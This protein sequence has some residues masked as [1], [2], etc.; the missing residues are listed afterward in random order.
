MITR[1]QS[2]PL[3]PA[4][5]LEYPQAGIPEARHE[6]PVVIV[7]GTLVDKQSIEAYRDY[8]IQKGHPVD[9]QNY[10]GIT[11]GALLQES[12]RQVSQNINQ[13]R[14]ELARTHLAELQGADSE[15]LAKFF[16]TDDSL[17]GRKVK[18]NL[19]WFVKRAASE[20]TAPN[21]D[22]LSS[23]LKKLEGQLEKRLGGEEWTARAAAHVVDCLAPKAT[24]VGHSAG[25]YIAYALALNPEDGQKSKFPKYDG[26]LGIGEVV[27]LSSP[28]GKGMNFPAPPGL[29]ELPYYQM[30]EKPIL[31]PLEAS[32][33]MK[34]A[35]LN[36]FFK[37]GYALSKT[38]TKTAWAMATQ[39]NTGLMS[40]VIF[41]Q[42][43]GYEQ[44]TGFSSFFKECLQ[45]KTVPEG[46]TVVAVT[47]K[48]DRMALPSHSRLEAA[49]PNAH[50]FEVDQQISQAELERERPTWGHVQMS[51]KPE[52]FEQQFEQSLLDHPAEAIRFLDPSND[53]GARYDVLQTLQNQGPEWLAGQ[54]DLKQAVARVAA[55][56]QPFRDSPS[57]LAQLLLRP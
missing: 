25:G 21:L 8:A 49:R 16:H 31:Q 38:A 20:V 12:A 5:R 27:V 47:S 33:L 51:M 26:G 52:L 43:P 55:E 4:K 18:E 1:L 19:E 3:P 40:P 9:W 13:A 11:D 30:V 6:R 29:A 45:D 54:P 42:K 14:Q 50:N 23:R 34:L 32:P 35:E 24:V 39:M 2:S 22:T 15:Q 36:P 10:Q 57:A 44:V 37:M 41:A 53:D 17:R 46:V 7:H 56:N 48:D 28:I